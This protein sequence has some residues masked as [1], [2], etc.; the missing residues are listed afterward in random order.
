MVH[1]TAR[2]RIHGARF[3]DCFSAQRSDAALRGSGSLAALCPRTATVVTPLPKHFCP[4]QKGERHCPGC[5]GRFSPARVCSPG[6]CPPWWP[7]ALPLLV[8]G[9]AGSV[10][11]AWLSGRWTPTRTPPEAGCGT[12]RR[13]WCTRWCPCPKAMTSRP[14]LSWTPPPSAEVTAWSPGRIRT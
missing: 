8:V 10:L 9:L 6:L 3:S 4:T 13:R 7:P 12:P 11:D 14:F 1:A 2:D 5:G